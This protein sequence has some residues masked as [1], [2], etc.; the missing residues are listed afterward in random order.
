[1]HLQ[2]HEVSPSLIQSS[3][4]HPKQCTGE[5]PAPRQVHLHLPHHCYQPCQPAST[6]HL[7]PS[8]TFPGGRRPRRTVALSR[9]RLSRSSCRSACSSCCRRSLSSACSAS[10]SSGGAPTA[11]P[12]PPEE[13]SRATAAS[14]SASSRASWS[15]SQRTAPQISARDFP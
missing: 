6:P 2:F 10:Q 7:L 12:P 3:N 5:K 15:R 14:A 1:M 9:A 4:H 8:L 11:A 13:R